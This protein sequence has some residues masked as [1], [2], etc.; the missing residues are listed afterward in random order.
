MRSTHAL[1]PACLL[2][3][4]ACDPGDEPMPIFDRAT[5]EVL[6][7]DL[8]V[9]AAVD[10]VP[11]GRLFRGERMDI[12]HVDPDGWVF[13]FAYGAVNRC[14]WARGSD[15]LDHGLVLNLDADAPG[16]HA[17]ACDDLGDVRELPSERWAA[18]VND[19]D[20]DLTAV[21]ACAEPKAF[22]NWDW[23]RGVGTDCVGELEPGAVVRWRYV[24]LD[25]GAALVRRSDDDAW[26]FAS[27]ACL[28][29]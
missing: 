20:D 4:A 2:A 12:H 6:A 19:R 29:L 26:V 1:I 11:L 25:G 21:R 15:A 5:Y 18:R 16:P 24:T 17:G 8:P 23:S 3:F 14:V 9:H 10:G 27:L 7:A 22:A 13:G 28:D